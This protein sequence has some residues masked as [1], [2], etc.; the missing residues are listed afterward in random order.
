[1]TAPTISATPKKALDQRATSRHDTAVAR[2]ADDRLVGEIEP[3]RL[4]GGNAGRRAILPPRAAARGPV[5]GVAAHCV[6]GHVE[7]PAVPERAQ[8]LHIFRMRPDEGH[9]R[10]GRL[11][12][13]ELLFE[14]RRG[15]P[16]LLGNE[17]ARTGLGL[18]RREQRLRLL[19]L[20]RRKGVVRPFAREKRPDAAD[21]DPVEGTPVR[22]L[23]VAVEVIAAPAGRSSGDLRPNRTSAIA[24]V[25][26]SSSAAI[27]PLPALWLRTWIS[28]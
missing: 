6:G 22:L 3:R 4:P 25:L 23:A 7:H 21:P 15:V 27:A 1:M 8:Q 2:I 13:Q 16:D 18:D 17:A 28:P 24:S 11:A 12:G 26:M 9:R 14:N 5:L 19:A 10:A 20:S